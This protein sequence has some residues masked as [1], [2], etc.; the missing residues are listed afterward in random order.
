MAGRGQKSGSIRRMS[1][2]RVTTVQGPSVDTKPDYENIHGPLGPLADMIFLAVFRKQLAKNAKIDSSKNIFDYGGI[3]DIAE[4]MTRSFPPQESQIRAQRTLR[5]L[6]PSWMPG[7][8]AVMFSKPFPEVRL[9]CFGILTLL[10]AVHIWL[11]RRIRAI[12]VFGTAERVGH[13]GRW[14][15]ADG[16][17]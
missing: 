8:F 9:L 2:L 7:S 16:R 12:A 15:L 3:M 17:M 13:Y 10:Y 4:C 1:E 11:I 6:F 5:S 14:D